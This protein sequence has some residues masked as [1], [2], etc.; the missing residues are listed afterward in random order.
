MYTVSEV[1]VMHNNIDSTTSCFSVTHHKQTLMLFT[2]KS[3]QAHALRQVFIDLHPLF[4]TVPHELPIYTVGKAGNETSHQ[5]DASDHN[6]N[7]LPEGRLEEED[8][9]YTILP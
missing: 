9:K 5:S 7:T 8:W 4:V 3:E 6:P 2:A 1:S